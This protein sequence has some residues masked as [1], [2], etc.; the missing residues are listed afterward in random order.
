MYPVK[1]ANISAAN[2]GENEVVAAVAG[3]TIVVI[4]YV[5]AV[6]HA[7]ARGTADFRSITANTVH[8]TFM[9][10]TD[11]LDGPLVYTYTGHPKAPAF[12]C[13]PGEAFGINN[14]AGVDCVGHV[15]YMLR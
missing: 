4:S 8:A 9:S 3:K 14:G 7:T 10:G 12:A 13:E 2:D 6:A 15:T 11:D 1:H 5:L